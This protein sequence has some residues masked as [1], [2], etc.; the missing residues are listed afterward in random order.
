M[1]EMTK[2]NLRWEHFKVDSYNFFPIISQEV[3]METFEMAN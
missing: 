2:K 1:L 3:E